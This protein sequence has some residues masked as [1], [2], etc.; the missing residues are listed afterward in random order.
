MKHKNKTLFILVIGVFSISI[1]SILIKLCTAPSLVISF[2]RMAIA[3]L[4]YLGGVSLYHGNIFKTITKSDF[5]YMLLSGVFLTF[6]FVTWITSLKYTSVASSV[7]LVQTS[8]VFVALGSYLF[9]K[10]K[11]G[12][13]GVSG[14]LITMAG[15]FIISR[16]DNAGQSGALFGNVLAVL[17]AIGASGYFLLGRKIRK[18]VDIFRYV[19]I[20][21]SVSTLL[22][23]ILVLFKNPVS[24]WGYSW[25]MMALLAAIA[26]VPQVI[27]HTSINWALKYYSATAVTIVTLAESV[28]ASLIAWLL[29]KEPLP[30]YKIVGGIILLSGVV[31]VLY[32]E[33]RGKLEKK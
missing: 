33:S 15:G 25:Q 8:P 31:L 22:L 18:T 16:Y 6:H 20:V 17:G 2:Y 3:S 14:I 19:A 28:C 27:G 26:L 5:K 23:L 11:P 9:F 7:V 13:A 12:L 10:E 4:F 32:A 29:L 30:V 24:L 1:S 21:Y